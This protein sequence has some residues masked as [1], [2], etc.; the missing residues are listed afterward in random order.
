[1]D[2]MEQM[3][4]DGYLDCP[5]CG[6]PARPRFPSAGTV[7]VPIAP[8]LPAPAAER[9]SS[10]TRSCPAPPVGPLAEPP[11]PAPAHGIEYP[12]HPGR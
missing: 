11:D 9:P 2:G 7:T 4:D 5:V 10:S 3:V 8:T 12:R 1:M 6:G